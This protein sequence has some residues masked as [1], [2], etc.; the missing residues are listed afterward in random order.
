MAEPKRGPARNGGTPSG[1]ETARG[2]LVLI[3]GSAGAIEALLKIVRALPPGFSSSIF[4]VIHTSAD[5]PSVLPRILSRA[6]QL[7]ASHPANGER[8]QP[9]HIYVAPPDAHLTLGSHGVINV[10]RGPRE[11][12]HRPAID[13]LFRSAVTAGYASRSIGVLLSGYLDDGSAGLYA[14]RSRG[15]IGVVQD[16]ADALV[17]DL[18]AN[19]L[20]YAGAEYVLSAERIGASLGQIAGRP[21]KVLAMERKKKNQIAARR[22]RARNN[23][24]ERHEEAPNEL[25]ATPEESNLGTPSVF[26]CPECHGVLW[27]IEEGGNVRY[28]CRVGHAYSEAT[29]N[30]QLS[31]SAES[32]LWAAMRALDEKASMSRRMA[33]ASTGPSRWSTRLR[34]Q[35]DTYAQH[36]EVL[37]RMILGEPPA[38]AAAEAEERERGR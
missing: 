35:A 18:P 9:G 13:P 4:V 20:A 16:P 31:Q 32:A 6:G 8:M 24:A 14:I 3:G 17:S 33:D 21:P 26:A 11:N 30:D 19:A 15:G 7:P 27:E 10:R 22:V 2:N 36:A 1:T 37:R 34:E 25:V 29:L 5:S 23:G 38:G 12:G 28:R